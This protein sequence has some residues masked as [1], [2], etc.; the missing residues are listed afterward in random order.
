M[1]EEG[2]QNS[3]PVLSTPILPKVCME[4]RIFALIY[5][6]VGYGFIYVFTETVNTGP[7]STFTVFY[8]VVVLLYLWAKNQKPPLESWF[9]LGVLLCIGIPFAFWTV[10]YIFQLLALMAVAAYWTLSATGR[11]LDG[12]TSQWV[13][14][15]GWNALAV[16]PFGNFCCQAQVLFGSGEE[17][18]EGQKGKGRYMGAVL[19]GIALA[20]PALII[21][22]PLLASADAGFERL[23]RDLVQY[24]QQHLL[25]VLLRLAF[26][27]PVSCY[28]YGLVFG[29]ISGR[30]TDQIQK[31]KLQKAGQGIRV[32]PDTAICTAMGIL[33]AIYLLF[34]G[35]QGNYL[36]SAFAGQIPQDFTYAEYAR[37]GF[38]EL[39][40]IGAWNLILL[41]CAGLFSKSECR[42]HRGLSLF[43]V[44][45]SV[46]T[47]LLIIT[48]MSKMGMYIS[49]YGLTV[50]RILPMVFMVW[51][52][53]VFLSIILRQKL[54]FPMV[55][56]CVMAGAVLF[57]LLC[58]FPVD[59]WIQLYNEWARA[60]G[61]IV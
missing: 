57:C 45:L 42:E 55:R 58:V 10:L 40:Q 33:C 48:A 11:L 60:R 8:A 44:L 13:F 25:T 19:L 47:L 52:V 30:K 22:L 14:F 29:G 16:V 34:M 18:E 50:N 27:V 43:T 3:L 6:L 1:Y 38:F 9:W 37:R 20:V 49:V 41:G 4:D 56:M 54:V 59:D 21:I 7:I 32:V 53:W 36:F 51:L 46:L 15:D 2:S 23:T 26:A 35:I 28:L 31:E 5:L 17:S 61:L 24:I 12:R 39:C